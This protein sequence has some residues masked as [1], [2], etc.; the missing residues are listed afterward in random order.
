MI[1][2]IFDAYGTIVHN[3]STK[4]LYKE[5]VKDRSIPSPMIIN[6]EFSD[7]L[8]QLNVPK[9]NQEQY[10]IQMENE[11]EN[12]Y[13]DQ[14][15]FFLIS[16]LKNRGH[17]ISI[18]SNLANPYSIPIKK[19]YHT[20]VDSFIFSYEIGFKKPQEEF[21]N[22][23]INEANIKQNTNLNANEF[24]MIGDSYKNDFSGPLRYGMQALYNVDERGKVD[25]PI[26][27][28]QLEKY[29]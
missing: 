7:L 25:W 23:I 21:Y 17:F 15:A 16:E 19:F 2:F 8:D 29:L 6:V 3:P 12:I 9:S 14:L 13:V 20:I 27:R 5:I 28:N 4:N 11:L 1:N 18:A 24:L 22:I 10:L 26:I